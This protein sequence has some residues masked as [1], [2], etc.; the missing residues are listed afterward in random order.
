[1]KG[2]GTVQVTESKPWLDAGESAEYLRSMG[3]GTV[4]EETIWHHVYD[5]GKLPRGK[6]VGKRVYWKRGA[7]DALVDKL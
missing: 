1:M 2:D 7:L 4:T 5:T 6:R 3:F